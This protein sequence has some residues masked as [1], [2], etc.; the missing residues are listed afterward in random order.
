MSP[1]NRE[2]IRNL[3]IIA[4]VDHG[5]T[6]LVDAMFRF[7]GTFRS[8][9]KMDVCVMDSNPQERERGIT[10]LAK[11]TSIQYLGTRI[12]VIDTPGHADFGGQ[13]ERTLSMADAALLLVDAHEGPMPQT[14]FVLRKAFERGLKALV[15]INK[16]DRPDQRAVEVLN[17]IFDLFVEL[18]AHDSQLDFPVVYGS[19]RAGIAAHTHEEFLSGSATDIKALF[20][21]LLAHMPVPDHDENAPLQFQAATIDHDDFMGRIAIGRVRHGTIKAGQRVA[22]CHPDR[23]KPILASV[24]QLMRFEGL[25]RVATSEVVAGDIAILGGI[26]EIKIGDT[27]C[28]PDM[29]NPLPAIRLEEPTI[30][31]VFQVN[32]SPF[33]G[34]EG[35][36]VT[37]RQISARLELASL[38]D[39][40]LIVAPTATPDSFEVKGRGVMHLGVLIETMRREGYEFCVGKPQ[41][42]LKEIDGAVHEPFERTAVEVPSDYAGKVIEYL[43]KRRGEML[44]ME[45]M[46]G[47]VLVEFLTPSR[48]LI[49]ARTALMT[50]SKGEA[51]LSH[52][53]ETWRPDGGAIPRRTNGVLVSDRA[54]D[55]IPYG[56][57][58]LLDRGEYFI[59]PGTPV[60]EGMIV[61]EHCK[62]GDLGINVCREKKLT[63]IRSAGRDEN[64][65]LPPPHRMSLEESLEY[66]ED[67]ELLE[68]TPKNMRLR[69]R[70]LNE[71][72]RRKATRQASRAASE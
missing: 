2:E 22:C 18:G 65:K 67:D 37:S 63:N 27:L 61:G 66:I 69:K 17:E 58:G 36:F 55:S 32:N 35:Q 51:I 13:V 50:L 52:V 60:Y 5:K 6:T 45:P 16:V 12:N 43:G 28:P 29:P 9:Q 62:E 57:F 46:G 10:I 4:H 34:K 70:V 15:M 44:H 3:A 72:D 41:V 11:N 48:G 1:S 7:A 56:M 23:P 30:S 47:S 21:M 53:F 49:G 24:K 54:G 25:Q 33:A 42:I 68:V 40:A 20:D 19:G 39:V 38:R 31:M 64:V 71:L 8:N 14:R 26:D 59:A